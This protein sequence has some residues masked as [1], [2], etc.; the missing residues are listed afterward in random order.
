MLGRSAPESISITVS[1]LDVQPA[2]NQFKPMFGQS[3]LK[4]HPS[5]KRSWLAWRVSKY[6]HALAWSL[7]SGNTLDPVYG[8]DFWCNRHGKTNTVDLEGSR[9]Q[10]WQTQ[11]R[12]VRDLP[13]SKLHPKVPQRSAA[14]HTPPHACAAGRRPLP[15]GLPLRRRRPLGKR[16]AA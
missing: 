9:G 13:D 3:I 4:T 8:A 1:S 16:W 14:T 12:P 5:F 15:R 2:P 6:R 7:E 11:K 10:I